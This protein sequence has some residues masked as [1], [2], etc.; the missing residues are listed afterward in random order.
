VLSFVQ[1]GRSVAGLKIHKVTSN[2][3][4]NTIPFGVTCANALGRGKIFLG[5]EDNDSVVLGWSRKS[6]NIGR[7]RSQ[8]KLV[9]NDEEFSFD[10]DDV[11]DDDDIYGGGTSTSK[12]QGRSS[13]AEPLVPKALTFRIHDRLPNYAPVG[14]ITFRR[15]DG[16]PSNEKPDAT[17]TE[18]L[19]PSGRGKDGGLV[20]CR[21]E[22]I[23]REA[24]HTKFDHTSAA[25]SFHAKPTSSTDL[26]GGE[27]ALLSADAAYH[28]F[29]I[30]SQIADENMEES[31]LYEVMPN[32]LKQT[33]RG[34]FDTEGGTLDVGVIAN[35]SWIVQVKT[36]ELRCYNS[37]KSFFLWICTFMNLLRI[38]HS[39][40]RVYL[41]RRQNSLCS[42]SIG[43]ISSCRVDE[44]S[45]RGK[46]PSLPLYVR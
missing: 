26:V 22:I 14:D 27:E 21:R 2:Q 41:C 35:G 24:F 40:L 19:Y 25:W 42:V 15:T 8:V 44:C 36:S 32:G 20:I 18:M 39:I 34:D 10:E 12:S 28:Q 3:G 5:N 38:R 45:P 9:D 37:G 16:N 29:A 33:E 30:V 17:N 1:D 46:E 7:K 23:P 31:T 11:E 13:I 6:T 4:G 43:C